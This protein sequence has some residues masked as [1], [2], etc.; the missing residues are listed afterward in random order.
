MNYKEN[1]V[2]DGCL[3][4]PPSSA[5]VHGCFLIVL[6]VLLPSQNTPEVVMIFTL[7]L[8]LCSGS[9]CKEHTIGTAHNSLRECQAAL[10]AGRHKMAYETARRR[11]DIKYQFECRLDDSQYIKLLG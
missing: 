6:W 1:S 11:S 4:R 9:G 7:I 2:Y 8:V 10:Y 3:F 5:I